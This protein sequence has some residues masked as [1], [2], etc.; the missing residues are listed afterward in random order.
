MSEPC[1]WCGKK[2]TVFFQQ[3][4]LCDHCWEWIML[5]AEKREKEENEPQPT[6]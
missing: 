4:C 2:A 5:E 3:E 1:N 6:P